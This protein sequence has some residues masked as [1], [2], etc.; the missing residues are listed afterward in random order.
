LWGGFEQILCGA[1]PG[2]W[3]TSQEKANLKCLP[4]RDKWFQGLNVA[5]KS[6]VFLDFW[7]ISCS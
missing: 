2:F 4:P 1:V 5:W 6:E 7:I 3:Q